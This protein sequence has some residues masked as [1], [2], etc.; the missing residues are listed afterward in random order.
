MAD[1]ASRRRFLAGLLAVPAAIVG[2]RA[3]A[4]AARAAGLVRPAP[5]GRS[6][7]RCAICGGADHVMLRC[8]SAPEV[9]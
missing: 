6:T 8:A 9:V 5:A 3:L 7:T 2:A 4:G 1:A